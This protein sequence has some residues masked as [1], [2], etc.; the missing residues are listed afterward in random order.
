MLKSL[1]VNSTVIISAFSLSA[2]DPTYGCHI[3]DKKDF[4]GEGTKLAIS[5]NIALDTVNVV[6]RQ[7]MR[8]EYKHD[9]RTHFRNYRIDYVSKLPEYYPDTKKRILD[10]GGITEH[11]G[12]NYT[13]AGVKKSYIVTYTEADNLFKDELGGD[14]ESCVVLN[15]TEENGLVLEFAIGL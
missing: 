2:K 13:F 11:D 12:G 5:G 14:A 8:S 9:G 6:C 15:Q 4:E 10:C 1:L 7:W 3:F